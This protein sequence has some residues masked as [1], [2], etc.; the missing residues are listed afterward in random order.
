VATRNSFTVDGAASQIDVRWRRYLA[1]ALLCAMLSAAAGCSLIS[2][3]SPE[4]PLSARD[5]NA[6]ILTHE[7]SL[8]FIAAVEQ[9][10][11]QIYA[12][13]ADPA[14]R[15]NALRWKIVASE[16]SEAAASQVAPMM[17]L[18]DTWALTVQMHEYLADGAGRSLFGT[19]QPLAVTLAQD[20]ASAA[21][22]LARRLTTADEFDHHQR[23]IDG[24]AQAH[25]IETL[26][27]ARPS[28]VELWTHDFGMQTKL[29]DTLGTVPEALADAGDLVRMY[30]E[31]GPS[32]M[33]WR[34]QL[35]VQQS[36]ISGKDLQAELERLDQRMA[37][38]SLLADSTPGLLNGVVRD[39]R[40][41]FSAAVDAMLRTVHTEGA[42]LSSSMSAERQSAVEA[43]D[44]QRAA[45]AADAARIASQVIRE[46]GEQARRLVR[47]M[48]LLAIGL[49]VIVLGLPFVAGYMLGRARRS[50]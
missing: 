49:A 33:L 46:T 17:G 3:K 20:Q 18:L 38:L 44:A 23:F 37:R 22:Q 31:S 4:K 9:T 15:V 24:Y 21:Q 45:F 29:V 40:A 19:Q 48:L 32:Q 16:K 12:G 10:A 35:A 5:L 47:E 36:G 14:V 41:S 6:R 1:H 42:T 11:D 8:Q 7:F 27:F 34:A 25:P 39:T 26:A 13:S 30:G 2:L 50:P 43:L 28:I